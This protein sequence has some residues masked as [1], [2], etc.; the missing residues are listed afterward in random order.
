MRESKDEPGTFR[1]EKD[2]IAQVCDEWGL[3]GKD[4]DTAKAII[5]QR[6]ERDFM[7]TMHLGGRHHTGPRYSEAVSTFLLGDTKEGHCEYFATAAVLLLRE[8]GIPARYCVGFSAQEKHK[9]SGDWIL[10]GRHAHAWARVYVGGRQVQLPDPERGGE[11]RTI[12]TGGEWVDFDPTPAGWFRIEGSVIPWERRV[13]DW[14]QRVREDVL[15]WRTT[16]GNSGIV[17]WGMGIVG[18]LLVG[19]I[20]L[21]LWQSRTGR[22]TGRDRG[23]RRGNDAVVTPLHELARPAE[24]WLGPRETGEAFT[25]WIAGLG[26]H[27]PA[28]LPNLQRAV[29]YHLKARFDPIGLDPGEEGEFRELCEHLRA[30][31][32]EARRQGN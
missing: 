17:N 13:L 21:R 10:R 15:L 1:G 23:R 24:H 6:F 30:R 16:P 20:T 7:Y 32:R 9:R 5:A 27:L 31:L 26:G 28:A 14:W 3:R 4:A 11:M 8:I 2:G 29:R 18:T 22:R 12:W 19:Y 25:E